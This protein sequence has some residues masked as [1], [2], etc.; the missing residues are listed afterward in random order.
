MAFYR[1]FT[2]PSFT[3]SIFQV[4][5]RIPHVHILTSRRIPVG[6]YFVIKY[7]L[8]NLR[9]L[10]YKCGCHKSGTIK[11]NT[12]WGT[13][14][15]GLGRGGGGKGKEIFLRIEAEEIFHCKY[16]FILNVTE[17]F[18]LTKDFSELTKVMKD[19]PLIVFCNIYI[20]IFFF[21]FSSQI[22]SRKITVSLSLP[23]CF[24]SYIFVSTF[25]TYSSSFFLSFIYF[26]FLS[27]T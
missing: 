26:S 19:L 14:K 7:I 17:T 3:I 10:F 2:S 27:N 13:V 4:T 25:S 20:Y 5:A 8:W 16:Y 6:D 24:Q 21:S 18:V 23:P 15:R 1:F 22:P 12:I 11:P 9:V